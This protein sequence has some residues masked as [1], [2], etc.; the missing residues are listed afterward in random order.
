[1]KGAKAR[2]NGFRQLYCWFN[3]HDALIVK[4]DRQEALVVVRLSCGQNWR[5]GGP[6]TDRHLCT[7]PRD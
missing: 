1:V 3:G 6:D 7:A 4:A 2:A 5:N